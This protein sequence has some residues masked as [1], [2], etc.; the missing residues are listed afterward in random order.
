MAQAIVG[1]EES[2]RLNWLGLQLVEDTQWMLLPMGADLGSGYL[3]VAL[4]L[5]QLAELTGIDRYADAARRAVSPLP[6]LL[7]AVAGQPELVAA[8]GCGG[9]SGLGGVSYGLA[10]LSRLLTD[11]EL[12]QQAG[13]A[14]ELAASV[15]LSGM[16]G[17]VTGTAG[18]LAALVA[19]QAEVGHAPVAALARA[20]ADRLGEL[21]EE[22]GGRCAAPGEPVPEGFA[23]GPAGIGWALAQFGEAQ[24]EPRY[25]AAGRLAARRALDAPPDDSPGWCRGLAGRLLAR[26]CLPAA[27]AGLQE[28]A[29]ALASR[30]VLTDLSL[31]H[32]EAG[33]A[34]VLT[35]LAAGTRSGTA[36]RAQRHRAGLLLDVINRYQFVCGTPGG[37][38]TPGLFSGLAGIGYELLR[39]GF[40]DQVP[41]T[42]L[43]QA[44]TPPS[45]S[46]G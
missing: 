36:R 3:G 34:D 19:V 28:A 14:A 26:A 40:A 21:A 41:S 45:N 1:E 11:P 46:H 20:C 33:I 42:L 22:T 25:L 12:G 31:C 37:V 24:A 10:R 35:V 39:L 4:F 17:W 13:M 32:G 18:C 7:A 44:G 6:G 16:P 5:A 8:I 38:M 29:S 9:I 23:S 27:G 43:L 15:S 30:P 2:G